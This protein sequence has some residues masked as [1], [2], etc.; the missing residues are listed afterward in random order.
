MLLAKVNLTDGKGTGEV[1]WGTMDILEFF[2]FAA[3]C[4]PVKMKCGRVYLYRS[5]THYL[6][7]RF[8]P[9][10]VWVFDVTRDKGQTWVN[11]GKADIQA[12]VD[13]FL[14]G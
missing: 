14:E 4:L 10:K 3:P 1:P 8:G 11:V 13:N 5:E 9:D 6:M 12:A 2:E 7:A